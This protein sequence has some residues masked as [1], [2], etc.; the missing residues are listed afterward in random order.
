VSALL[1]LARYDAA[2]LDDKVDFDAMSEVLAALREATRYGRIPARE[3]WR[4]AGI[5]GLPAYHYAGL[6]IGG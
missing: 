5:S 1:A 6:C 2:M 4:Q 3:G